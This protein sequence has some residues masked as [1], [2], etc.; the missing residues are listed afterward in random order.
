[1]TN[2]RQFLK[3]IGLFSILA[4]AGRVWKATARPIKLLPC[5]YAHFKSPHFKFMPSFQDF[6]EQNNLIVK[7][8]DGLVACVERTIVQPFTSIKRLQ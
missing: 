1:M 3:G 4:G 6:L 7:H 2:R 5:E 8:R